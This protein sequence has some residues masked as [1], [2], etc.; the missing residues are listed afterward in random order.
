MSKISIRTRCIGIIGNIF[1]HYDN[2]LFG[3]L[4]P[5]IASQ[6]FETSD[7]I[8]ALI[9]TYG[10]LPLGI[11]FRPIGSLFFGWIGD[12]YGRRQ[13]LCLSLTGMAIA[14]ISMGCLPTYATAG[15]VAP[16]LLALCRILQNFFASG[17]NVGGAI[18][19]LEHA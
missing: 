8:T 3:L 5:F 7:P 6:F 10:I 12:R 18:F 4:A 14:T 1:E 2:A 17:E 19:L 16:C 9:L 11:V 15:I 13:A